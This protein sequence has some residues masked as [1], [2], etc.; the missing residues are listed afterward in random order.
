M[1]DLKPCPKCGSNQI[2]MDFMSNFLGKKWFVQCK[3]CGVRSS[4]FW[5]SCGTGVAIDNAELSWN[6]KVKNV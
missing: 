2:G 4:Y 3:N 1:T 6:E 5:G